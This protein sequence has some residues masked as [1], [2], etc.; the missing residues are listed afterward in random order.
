MTALEPNWFVTYCLSCATAW[1]PVVD[2]FSAIAPD[3]CSMPVTQTEKF[4]SE[5]TS[6]L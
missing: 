4:W 5:G 1:A 6:V 2:G 3:A